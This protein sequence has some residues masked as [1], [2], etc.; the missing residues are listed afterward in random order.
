MFDGLLF[1]KAKSVI[2]RDYEE[3]FV[4]H[5]RTDISAFGGSISLPITTIIIHSLL[6]QKSCQNQ[7]ENYRENQNDT[8]AANKSCGVLQFNACLIKAIL[9]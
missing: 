5:P 2:D 3:I 4:C 9:Y 7:L 1:I 6:S 8:I